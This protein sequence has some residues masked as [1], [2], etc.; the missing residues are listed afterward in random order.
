MNV[1]GQDVGTATEVNTGRMN[2]ACSDLSNIDS[3]G[4]ETSVCFIKIY[5]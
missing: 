4:F 1:N 2:G 5:N 3:T